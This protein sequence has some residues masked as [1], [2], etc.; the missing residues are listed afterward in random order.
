MLNFS[1]IREAIE[2]TR[3]PVVRALRLCEELAR[4]APNEVAHNLEFFLERIDPFL[5]QPLVSAEVTATL[6]AFL[7]A[8]CGLKTMQNIN[9]VIR[10]YTLC[11]FALKKNSEARNT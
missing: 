1:R 6:K 2:N 5:L 3:R 4:I 10:A 8:S 11:R 7:D 9:S